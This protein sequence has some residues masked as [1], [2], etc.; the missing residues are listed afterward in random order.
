MYKSTDMHLGTYVY[1][2]H[3][4]YVYLDNHLYV[5]LLFEFRNV[6]LLNAGDVGRENDV[7]LEVYPHHEREQDL[8]T[9]RV[10]LLHV[11][12]ERSVSC[13]SIPQISLNKT[14]E[15]R[16]C[17]SHAGGGKMGPLILSA[18]LRQRCHAKLIASSSPCLAQEVSLRFIL[19]TSA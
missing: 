13:V 16:D 10:T 8:C 15:P 19:R 6:P 7:G 5:S 2:V 4:T 12:G 14:R 3:G 9:S 11:K 1:H 17:I 18:F